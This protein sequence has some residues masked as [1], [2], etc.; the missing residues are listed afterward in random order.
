MI[1]L[2]MATARP[3]AG[4]ATLLNSLKKQTLV[5]QLIEFILVDKAFDERK[6]NYLKMMAEFDED[7][8]GRL[9]YM[10]DTSPKGHVSISSARN[11]GVTAST[12]DWI[13]SIDDRT[14]LYPNTLEMHVS[15]FEKGWDA[16]A[17]FSDFVHKDRYAEKEPDKVDERAAV[18]GASHGRF[19]AQHF[20]GYHMAFTKKAWAK[21]NGFD[22]T[23]DGTYGW[24]DI[25]FGIRMFN[26]GAVIRLAPD[27]KVLQVRDSAH[28]DTFDDTK[29]PKSFDGGHVRWLNDNRHKL[30]LM[31]TGRMKW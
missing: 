21:V 12:N 18:P 14:I 3:D 25:D 22:E 13:V 5:H 10:K 16:I 7:F 15:F 31:N 11:K 17:G 2:I 8:A 24:E 9:R 19:A 1:T 29:V 28:H 4:L 30:T 23:F 20:Y 26:S 27:C 6:P